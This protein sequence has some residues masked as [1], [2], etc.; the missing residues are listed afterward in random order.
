MFAPKGCFEG[1]TS[2]AQEMGTEARIKSAHFNG[3]I[4]ERGDTLHVQPKD[5]E[6]SFA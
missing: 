5:Y 1:Q 2:D 4:L 6:V 3:S